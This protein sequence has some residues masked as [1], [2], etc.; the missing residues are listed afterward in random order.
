M[1][2]EPSYEPIPEDAAEP[3]TKDFVRA[4]MKKLSDEVLQKAERTRQHVDVVAE[5]IRRDVAMPQE[6]RFG[7]HD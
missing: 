6:A 4:E 7:T 5:N 2:A 3:A 1:I